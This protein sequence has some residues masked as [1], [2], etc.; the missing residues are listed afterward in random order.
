MIS[1]I[2]GPK[3]SAEVII[4]QPINLVWEVVTDS[5]NFSDIIRGG[6]YWETFDRETA[7]AGA[8]FKKGNLPNPGDEAKQ[9]DYYIVN[10]NPPYQ[11]SMGSKPD[12]WD[13]DFLLTELDGKTKVR[14]TRRFNVLGFLPPFQQMV[15]YAATALERKCM[16]IANKNTP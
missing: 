4:E 7:Q 13:H 3:K 12:S 5:K 16:E 11:F 10:W 15:D 9:W 2:P 1:K 14:I 6:W 8:S